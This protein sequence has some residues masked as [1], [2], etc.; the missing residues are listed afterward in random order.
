MTV[1]LRKAAVRLARADAAYFTLGWL[2][3]LLVVGTVAQKFSPAPQAA[4][5]FFSSLL[6][7]LG[8]VP[9]PG[10]PVT[11]GILALGLLAKLVFST[12]WR[13]EH[14]GVII[15]HLGVLVLLCGGLISAIARQEG[16]LLLYEGESTCFFSA[17]DE[18]EL[19]ITSAWNTGEHRMLVYPA[20]Q[21][22]NNTAV[23]IPGS[24]VS[25]S[26]LQLFRDGVLVKRRDASGRDSGAKRGLARQFDLRSAQ[27]EEER[28]QARPAVVFC[29]AGAGTD[30]DGI[31]L[32][33]DGLEPQ[34]EIV[35][36]DRLVT[37]E[38]QRTRINLAFEIRLVDFSKEVYPQTDIPRFYR[39]E[40]V[41]ADEGKMLAAHVSMNAPLRYRGY[42]FYQSAFR[43][44]ADRQATVLLVV[45]DRGRWFPYAASVLI[46]LGLMIHAGMRRG[47]P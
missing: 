42:V 37:I 31:Y 6:L 1:I 18:C 12:S 23:S 15:V 7:W 32:S 43:E 22:R 17:A 24:T 8:P 11:L 36:R 44:E 35:L 2:M 34:P 5:Y 38:F 47:K 4:R 20:A 9:L 41:I 14:A 19:A 16:T 40:V 30:V 13:R 27:T 39:S 3:V 21:L 28:T 45:K 26:V 33:A 25:V 10:M 29:I 46:S